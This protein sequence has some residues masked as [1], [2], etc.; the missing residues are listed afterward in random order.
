MWAYGLYGMDIELE[1]DQHANAAWPW[2][3]LHVPATIDTDDLVLLP[4]PGT[5]EQRVLACGRLDLHVLRTL[6]QVRTHIRP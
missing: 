1:S 6:S 4:D 3:T 5:S 2:G